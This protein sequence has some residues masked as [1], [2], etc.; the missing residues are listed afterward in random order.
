M[1]GRPAW[2]EEKA[3]AS[4]RLAKGA[5]TPV[6]VEFLCQILERGSVAKETAAER[7]RRALRIIASYMAGVTDERQL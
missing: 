3:M 6:D 1:V 7:E 4:A 5:F 2:E